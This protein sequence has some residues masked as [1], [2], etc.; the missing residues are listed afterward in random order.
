VEAQVASY[1]LGALPGLARELAIDAEG[2]PVSLSIHRLGLA[3]P[4]HEGMTTQDVDTV[5]G[6]VQ[7]W[8]VERGVE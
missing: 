5:R 7:D 3:L 8:L 4:L 1:C 6:L 2:T